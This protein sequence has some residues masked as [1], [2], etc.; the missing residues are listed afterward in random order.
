MIIYINVCQTY[1][2]SAAYGNPYLRA[3]PVTS[4][5]HYSTFSPPD[6]SSP[7]LHSGYRHP[8]SGDL[9]AAVSKPTNYSV[10]LGGGLKQP[11]QSF[12]H[13]FSESPTRES[14]EET[15]TTNHNSALN[16]SNSSGNNGRQN[17]SSNSVG[18][19]ITSCNGTDMGTNV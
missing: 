11:N 19:Y 4:I 10:A 12:S 6:S 16:G 7:V 5:P 8:I 18:H 3:Q 13:S 14:S 2:Y 17:G 1:R 9:Y 15:P